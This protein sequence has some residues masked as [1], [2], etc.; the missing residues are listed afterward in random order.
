MNNNL[1]QVKISGN[2]GR[3]LKNPQPFSQGVAVHGVQQRQLVA[4]VLQD[5]GLVNIV[6]ADNG[7]MWIDGELDGILAVRNRLSQISEGGDY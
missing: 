4:F 5:R 6:V 1:C 2:L 3:F 7:R